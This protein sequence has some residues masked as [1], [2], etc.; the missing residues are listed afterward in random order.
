ML[1]PLEKTRV[2]PGTVLI[3]TVLSG[4]SL[5]LISFRSCHLLEMLKTKLLGLCHLA[6]Q[7]L[8]LNKSGTITTKFIVNLTDSCPTWSTDNSKGKPLLAQL[9]LKQI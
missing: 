5:Y 9:L 2:K 6:N 7:D 4:D 1:F 3:E 8:V